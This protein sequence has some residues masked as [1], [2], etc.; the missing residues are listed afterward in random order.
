MASWGSNSKSDSGEDVDI[1]NLCFIAQGGDPTTVT[2]ETSLD[3]ND[4]T[5]DELANFW[6]S[7][8]KCIIY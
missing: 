2:L 1:A 6:K 5:I 4:L 8:K 3:D 7:F